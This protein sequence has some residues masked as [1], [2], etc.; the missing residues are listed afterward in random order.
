MALNAA[1]W[2]ALSASKKKTTSSANLEQ[3]LSWLSVNAVPSAA[4]VFLKPAECIAIAS[5]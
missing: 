4:T 5:I 3:S 1:F 2:P